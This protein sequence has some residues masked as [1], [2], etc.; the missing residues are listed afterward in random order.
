M[1]FGGFAI[2]RVAGTRALRRRH[3][4]TI[5]RAQIVRVNATEL[6][7]AAIV[8]GEFG[9]AR[10]KVQLNQ[11]ANGRVT[12]VALVRVTA[13][14]RHR[15]ATHMVATVVGRRVQLAVVGDERLARAVHG[16]RR[17]R[18]Q[19]AIDGMARTATIANKSTA[20]GPTNCVYAT[21]S[22]G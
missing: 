6:T 10:L 9:V 15:A 8:V 1:V 7:E 4:L 18:R 14:V 22:A 16:A 2:V 20:T 11:I 21:G 3:H 12:A 13:R 17:L 5:E 19:F